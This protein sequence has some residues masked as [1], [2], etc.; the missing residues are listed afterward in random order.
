MCNSIVA[1]HSKAHFSALLSGYERLQGT[2]KAFLLLYLNSD[3]R[4]LL[5]RFPLR[6]EEVL[7]NFSFRN[8]C[9]LIS[10]IFSKFLK[11]N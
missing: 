11:N 2:I 7:F 10:D 6:V 8:F 5:S 1:P 9:H 4:F 3:S